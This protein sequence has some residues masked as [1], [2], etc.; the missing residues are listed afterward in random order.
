MKN[1]NLK[2]SK[3]ALLIYLVQNSQIPSISHSWFRI[4]SGTKQTQSGTDLTQSGT[5]L[6]QSGTSRW[7]HV[8]PRKHPKRG[9]LF[10]T[11]FGNLSTGHIGWCPS[12]MVH[13]H[14]VRKGTIIWPL[15]HSVSFGRFVLWYAFFVK[16]MGF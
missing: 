15:G 8:P 9:H 1:P 16:Q 5:D 2:S 12:A 7:P 10:P 4:T 13:M 14:G 11:C 3:K 6:T